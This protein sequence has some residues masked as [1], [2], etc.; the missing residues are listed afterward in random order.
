MTTGSAKSHRGG[1]VPATRV[2]RAVVARPAESL[3]VQIVAAVGYTVVIVT[4]AAAASRFFTD[5]FGLGQA[6]L[7]CPLVAAACLAGIRWHARR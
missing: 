3:G 4:L 1:A 5:G 7:A 2:T 6:G